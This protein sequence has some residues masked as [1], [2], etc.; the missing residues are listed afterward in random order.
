MDILKRFANSLK[1]RMAMHI[2]K[3]NPSKAKQW[4]EEAVA[5]GVIETEEQE[6]CFLT[7]STGK[8]NPLVELWNTWSDMRMGAG[9]LQSSFP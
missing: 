7:A 8:N 5:S 3:V 2:V 9:G 1:L 4:A 6:V